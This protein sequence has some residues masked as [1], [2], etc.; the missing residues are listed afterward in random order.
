[1]APPSSPG[2]ATV[3]T[4]QN[5]HLYPGSPAAQVPFSC[6][7][8][9]VLSS[10]PLLHQGRYLAKVRNLETRQMPSLLFPKP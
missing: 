2:L 7:L 10:S 4:A 6:L 1:M 9:L 5:M 3:I 8:H